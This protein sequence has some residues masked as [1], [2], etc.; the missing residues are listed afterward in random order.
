MFLQTH[1]SHGDAT[2]SSVVDADYVLDPAGGVEGQDTSQPSNNDQAGQALSQRTARGQ[3]RGQRGGAPSTLRIKISGLDGATKLETKIPANFLQGGCWLLV[4]W[5]A[6][7]DLLAG[8]GQLWRESS[9]A[10]W[11]GWRALNA[12]QQD[13]SLDGATKLQVIPAN[14]L[15]GVPSLQVVCRAAPALL[16]LCKSGGAS[17]RFRWCKAAGAAIC[18]QALQYHSCM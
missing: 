17:N 4:V 9:V 5:G 3:Q 12:A 14:F 16:L 11:M 10:R 1:T 6:A 2:S 15:Q 18:M 13:R 7:L 8:M